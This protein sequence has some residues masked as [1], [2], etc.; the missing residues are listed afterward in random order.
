MNILLVG[1]YSG[2]HNSLKKGL[3]NL[4]H[5]V[6]IFAHGDGFKKYPVDIALDI[7]KFKNNRP[8]NFIKNVIFRF[9]GLDISMFELR[10]KFKKKIK[11]IEQYDAVQFINSIPFL[12]TPKT[13]KFIFK[14]ITKHNKNCYLH[15]GSMEVPWVDYMLHQHKGF[16]S[17]TPYLKNKN[18]KKE[19]QYALKYTKPDFIKYYQFFSKNIKGII[20]S[21]IDYEIVYRNT[22]KALNMIPTPIDLSKLQF[23]PLNIKNK[24]NIFCGINTNNQ[25]AKGI[26]YFLKALKTIQQKYPDKV[27]VKITR[28]LPYDAYMKVYN[29]SHILLDQCLSYDQGYNGREAM[30]R[31]KVVFS[32]ANDDFKSYYKLTEATM[33]LVEAKPDVDYLVH[34]LSEL[35]ENPEL[36][37]QI[38]YRA[39][40]FIEK[41]HECTA[42][43]K[44]YLKAWGL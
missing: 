11:L 21:D 8:L 42:V 28:N 5:D 35:I 16:S 6:T 38:S 30:G 18:L 12:A 40:K 27:V 26:S 15:G 24:I 39:R 13:E 33:P 37:L 36:M 41:H 1:E 14:N 44:Q 17:F 20:P 7:Q 25:H 34:K 4:G 22:S 19:F 31:G 32:G 10:M 43:A 23:S 29:E 2:F 3:M 9:T